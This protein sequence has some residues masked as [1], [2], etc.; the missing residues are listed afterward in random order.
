MRVFRVF[1]EDYSPRVIVER[2]GVFYVPS[3]RGIREDIGFDYYRVREIPFAPDYIEIEDRDFRGF[4]AVPVE[5]RA[6][7]ERV[8]S[9]YRIVF[10]DGRRRV[11][12]PIPERVAEFIR[13]EIG[14]EFPVRVF[15]SWRYP[16][17][18]RSGRIPSFEEVAEAVAEGREG[19]EYYYPI[20]Y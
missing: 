15:A 9:G 3:W 4:P 17:E 5:V 20:P 16:S 19:V 12:F 2:G 14:E 7:V 13:R 1:R 18:R 8:S 11:S 6:F 10:P